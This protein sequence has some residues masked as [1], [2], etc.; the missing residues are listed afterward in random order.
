MKI[1]LQKILWIPF[2]K[3]LTSQNPNF[4]CHYR[5]GVLING[6]KV[7]SSHGAVGKGKF[8]KRAVYYN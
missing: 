3:I 8:Q 4:F 6:L 2:L 7:A 5:L 1:Y